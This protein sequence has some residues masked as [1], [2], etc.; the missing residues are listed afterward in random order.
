MSEL[1]ESVTISDF[2]ITERD[3]DD[4]Q[5]LIVVGRMGAAS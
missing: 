1:V 3:L 2:D 4:A 5:D